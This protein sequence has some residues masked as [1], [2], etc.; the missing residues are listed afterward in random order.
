MRMVCCVS[1]GMQRLLDGDGFCFW[2]MAEILE[3]W[4]MLK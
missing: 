2:C 3:G 1:C 4:E